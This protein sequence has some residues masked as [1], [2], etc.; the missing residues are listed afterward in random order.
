MTK[1][2]SRSMPGKFRDQHAGQEWLTQEQDENKKESK[3]RSEKRGCV[4]GGSRRALVSMLIYSEQDGKRQ[5]DVSQGVTWSDLHISWITLAV[6]SSLW[7]TW[8]NQSGSYWNNPRKRRKSLRPSN[9]R[10]GEEWWDSGHILKIESKDLLT[11]WLWGVRKRKE[12][13]RTSR[14]FAWATKKGVCELTGK[15][16]GVQDGKKIRSSVVG[17]TC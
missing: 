15:T 11:D 9:I 4:G 17:L 14:S 16:Y 7:R 3:V 10:N 12:L 13:N 8:W 5:Y 1:P 6:E 2:R